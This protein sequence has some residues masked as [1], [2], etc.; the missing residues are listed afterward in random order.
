MSNTFLNLRVL[1]KLDSQIFP[2][3]TASDILALNL[4]NAA[5]S[6]FKFTC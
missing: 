5:C 1:N 3:V 4:E 6:L 2:N